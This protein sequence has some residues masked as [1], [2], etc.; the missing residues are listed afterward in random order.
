MSR[1]LVSIVMT[2]SDVISDEYTSNR[3]IIIIVLL[4]LLVALHLAYFLYLP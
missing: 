4:L 3:T 2:S 1:A